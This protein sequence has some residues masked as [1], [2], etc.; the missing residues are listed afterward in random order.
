MGIFLRWLGAFVLLSATFNPT[1]WNYIRWA[2]ANF[3]SQMPLAILLGL[4]LALGYMIYI[5]AT[6]RSIG[7]IG[8]AFIAAIFGVAV[9]FFSDLGFLTLSNRDLNLWLGILALS[10]ILGVG[11]SWSILRQKLSGQATVDQV[12]E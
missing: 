2:E 12:D 7:V 4:L 8:I 5:A 11:L 6:L 10:L 1:D 9:W 3:A